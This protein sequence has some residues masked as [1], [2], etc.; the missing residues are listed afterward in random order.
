MQRIPFVGEG[1]NSRYYVPLLQAYKNKD[2]KKV[3][4]LEKEM[5]QKENE[6]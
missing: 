2:M 1:K 6:I 5:R 3:A 4:E